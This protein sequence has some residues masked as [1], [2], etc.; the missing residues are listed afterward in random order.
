M[1][2]FIRSI[3]QMENQNSELLKEHAYLIARGV[4]PLA[5]VGHCED[6]E[7]GMLR[8]AT[9]LESAG[10]QG[11]IPFVMPRGDGFADYGFASAQWV[12]DLLSWL[13]SDTVPTVHRHRVL[14]LLL[15]YDSDAIR[16]FGEQAECRLF[17]SA[18]PGS[19]S[20]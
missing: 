18:S 15:G 5:L 6:D 11:A 20:S 8:W 19:A 9:L 1:P 12:L 14:G 7:I 2:P 17:S 3:L 16:D 4:R 13:N 10:A